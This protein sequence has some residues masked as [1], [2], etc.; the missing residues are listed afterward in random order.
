MRIFAKSNGR[1]RADNT[2]NGN[3]KKRSAQ[4][5]ALTA[6]SG[7]RRYTKNEPARGGALTTIQRPEAE[8]TPNMGPD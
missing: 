5:G 4:W 3:T 6:E 8:D 7:G 2:E 1:H